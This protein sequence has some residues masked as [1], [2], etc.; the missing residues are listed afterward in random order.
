VPAFRVE[1]VIG[2]LV[3]GA[4]VVLALTGHC[5]ASVGPFAVH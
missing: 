5:S 2:A 3:I 4:F 1:L